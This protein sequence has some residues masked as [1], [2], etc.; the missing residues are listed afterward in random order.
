[1]ALRELGGN[2]DYGDVCLWPILLNK[3]GGNR[4][5]SSTIV[6]ALGG[7]ILLC[8]LRL[9]GCSASVS[10]SP[11]SGGFGRWLRGGTHRGHHSVLVVGAGQA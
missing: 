4:V 5:G 2:F 7:A 3:S 6:G 10:V 9:A 11:A 8:S 1:M